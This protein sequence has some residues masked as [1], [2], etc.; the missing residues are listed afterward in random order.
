MNDFTRDDGSLKVVPLTM[1]IIPCQNTL[2]G[3]SLQRD[4]GSLS[5]YTREHLQGDHDQL[6][7][8]HGGDGPS[9][10]GKTQHTIATHMFGYDHEFTDAWVKGDVDTIKDASDV[11]MLLGNDQRIENYLDNTTLPHGF[12]TYT[13]DAGETFIFGQ[14]QLPDK[15]LQD[16]T[17]MGIN[18]DYADR[19]PEGQHWNGT[20][21]HTATTQIQGQTQAFTDAFLKSEVNDIK[22]APIVYQLHGSDAAINKYS[23]A[24]TMPQDFS[25]YSS[26][27]GNTYVFGYENLPSSHLRQMKNAG[28][29]WTTIDRSGQPLEP[30]V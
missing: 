4:D 26:D 24:T 13:S 16:L 19:S 27:S 11:Y 6:T 17:T 10:D 3:T 2:H 29:T 8:G 7:H 25:M 1:S 23:D 22:N 21:V 20:T 18:Y 5:R 9:Y 15:T 12:S 28:V 30:L 14:H